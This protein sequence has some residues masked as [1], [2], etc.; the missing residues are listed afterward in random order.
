YATT[1]DPQSPKVS[2]PLTSGATA[3]SSCAGCHGQTGG[4]GAGPALTNVDE[5]FPDPASHVR[6]VLLGTAGYQSEG[7]PTY[8]ADNKPVGGA[9]NMPSQVA[10]DSSEL[11]SIIRHERETLAGETYDEQA[12][13]DAVEELLN[14]PNPEVS[15][16]A[17]E[18]GAIV[19]SWANFAPGS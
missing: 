12:W 19:E 17:E 4:G 15:S 16:K 3:Y 7:T 8:G 9:G 14:D 2:G 5:L 11:L 13:L 6:W 18:Y 10:L 1:N